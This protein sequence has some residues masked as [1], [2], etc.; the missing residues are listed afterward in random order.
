MNEIRAIADKS[1]LDGTA[2]IELMP[3]KYKGVC[4]NDGSLFFEEEVFGYFEPCIERHVPDFDHYAFTEMNV[5]QCVLVASGLRDL[6]VLAQSAA[7]I[8]QLQDHVGFIFQSSK[9]RFE[10]DFPENTSA[11]ATL[12]EELADWLMCQVSSHEQISILGI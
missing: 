1:E 8:E 12:A 11:L 6:A 7:D 5:N 9:H 3:G 10:E 2:Y 4:W